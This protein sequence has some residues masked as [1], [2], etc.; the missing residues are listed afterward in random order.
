MSSRLP[1]VTGLGVD[2]A[3]DI[4]MATFFPFISANETNVE[5]VWMSYSP[6][7]CQKEQWLNMDFSHMPKQYKTVGLSSAYAAATYYQKLGIKV[8]DFAA[9]QGHP[10]PA[11]C[12]FSKGFQI[13]LQVPKAQMA[14]VTLFGFTVH[15]SP[16]PDDRVG[17]AV[18]I[19]Q[20]SVSNLQ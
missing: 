19:V 1:V 8:Y 2:S 12:G 7:Q 3:L 9:T 14:R 15:K 11:A 20:P 4:C 10:V 17:S 16:G 6:K 18:V 13:L 5:K